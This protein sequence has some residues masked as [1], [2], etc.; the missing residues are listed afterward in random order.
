MGNGRLSPTFHDPRF[1]IRIAVVVLGSDMEAACDYL[2]R[3]VLPELEDLCVGLGATLMVMD[4]DQRVRT[5]L[6]GD[7]LDAPGANRPYVI[8]LIGDRDP[9]A[10][11][12]EPDAELQRR[13]PWLRQTAEPHRHMVDAA[14]IE[15]IIADP[16]RAS[17]AFFYTTGQDNPA[18]I[19]YGNSTRP[20][21]PAAALRKRIRANGFA[22]RDGC[23]DPETLSRYMREDLI[24]AID[25]QLSH[26]GVETSIEADRRRHRAFA[27]SRC[28]AYVANESYLHILDEYV[29]GSPTGDGDGRG[30]VITGESGAGKS[31][32]VAYWSERY[33]REHPGAFLIEH[34]IGADSAGGDHFPIMR[35]IMAEIRE[36][37]AIDEPLPSDARE[38]EEALPLW[39][40]NVQKEHL[41]VII[42]A[43]DRLSEPS[44]ALAWL[45]EYLQ[46]HLRVIVATSGDGTLEQLRERGWSELHVLPLRIEERREIV[47]RYFR[48]SERIVSADDVQRFS[49]DAGSANPLFLR[50]RLQEIG[51]YASSSKLNERIDY[52]L[53]AR[54]LDDLFERILIRLE[55]EHGRELAGDVLALIWASSNGLSEFELAGCCAAH[56]D[57][58][59]RLLDALEHHLISHRGQLAFFH[60]RMRAAVERRYV[61]AGERSA[62]V[63][64]R[65]LAAYFG[66]LPAGLRRAEE[67][68]WQLQRAEEWSA[69]CRSIADIPMFMALSSPG[70]NHRLLAYW[71]AIG[72]RFDPADV[73]RE[74]LACFEEGRSEHELVVPLGA[75]GRFFSDAGRYAEAEGYCARV[76]ELQERTLGDSHADVAATLDYLATLHYH[77]GRGAEA[78]SLLRRA[79]V[80]RERILGPEHLSIARNLADLGAGLY[81]MGEFDEA[82]RRLSDAL[83]IGGRQEASGLPVVAMILNNLGALRIAT[84]SYAAAVSY[85]EKARRINRFLFGPEHPEVASN[86]VNHAFALQA[87]GSTGAAEELYRSALAISEKA[88]GPHHPQVAITL[89]NL[90]ALR[91]DAGDMSEAEALFSRALNIR[92]R[93]FGS[94]NLETLDSMKRLGYVLK[95]RGDY[96]GAM[97]LYEESVRGYEKLCGPAYPDAE[98]LRISMQEM[99]RVR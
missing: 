18:T 64:H 31:A 97:R 73:Y 68:P 67:E 48:T 19:S 78:T 1:Q 99:P 80:I 33:R 24:A 86:L 3:H 88:L 87:Q 9:M 37:Y 42:D 79:L 32:L 6:T 22:L 71:L 52:F 36:R 12:P 2:L 16:V 17:H 66:T 7:D 74:S 47:R 98:Q 85:F 21:S 25:R 8:G 35:R 29:A 72:N 76:L 38:I 55:Q 14:L 51:R 82:E 13:F 58:L 23:S 70:G 60:D 59:S 45:P 11:Q 92:R 54:D 56:G 20:E 4:M 69:L 94:D 77:T 28:R 84:G 65:R 91:R 53:E 44:Q 27:A 57:S 30:L 50:T 40:G 93:V 83:A 89:T 46:P 34:Y 41:L 43:L 90:G 15:E 62:A 96:A 39:L 81:A 5:I 49:R 63:L 61:L 10:A 26:A 95:R 75:L